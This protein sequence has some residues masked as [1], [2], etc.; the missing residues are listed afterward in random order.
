MTRAP[1]ALVAALRESAILFG[2]AISALLLKE[3]PP[4]RRLIAAAIIA[5]GVVVLRLS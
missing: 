1:V 4:R 2:L 5:L 3:R